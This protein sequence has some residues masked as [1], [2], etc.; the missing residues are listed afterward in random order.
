MFIIGHPTG[1]QVLIYIM[2]RKRATMII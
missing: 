2:G 1:D